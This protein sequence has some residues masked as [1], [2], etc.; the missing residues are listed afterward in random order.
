MLAKWKERNQ[1]KKAYQVVG[2]RNWLAEIWKHKTADDLPGYTFTISRMRDGEELERGHFTAADVL[3]L[4]ELTRVLAATMVQDGCIPQTLKETLS[5]LADALDWLLAD[6]MAGD[7]PDWVFVRREPLQGV[8]DY[9]FDE[10]HKSFHAAM[11]GERENHIFLKL[12][13]LE[14]ALHVTC[15]NPD[16]CPY[17]EKQPE[18]NDACG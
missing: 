14:Q 17:R 5:C 1:G 3:D 10:E 6:A 18:A 7:C 2:A 13:E 8:V 4:P 12:G 15:P 9:L 11:G 16:D